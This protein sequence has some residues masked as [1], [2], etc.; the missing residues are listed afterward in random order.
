MA[1]LLV[2][3]ISGSTVELARVSERKEGI[4]LVSQSMFEA[5]LFTSFDSILRLYLRKSKGGKRIARL[6][7]SPNLPEGEAPF[8]VEEAG[9]KSC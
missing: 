7:D 4:R 5:R 3:F 1:S 2:G 8:M 6:V 9:L